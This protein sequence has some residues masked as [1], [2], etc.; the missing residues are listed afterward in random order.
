MQGVTWEAREAGK[1]SE[2]NV[3]EVCLG[4]AWRDSLFRRVIQ[5]RGSNIFLH[6]YV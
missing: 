2:C 6:R 3:N 5:S 4:D 1:R